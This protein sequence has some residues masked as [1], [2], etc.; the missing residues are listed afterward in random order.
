MAI[1]FTLWAYGRSVTATHKIPWR[2][3]AS[4]GLLL[5]IGVSVMVPSYRESVDRTGGGATHTLGSLTT[6][7][8]DPER[9]AAYIAEGQPTFLYFT[10]DWCVTCKFNERTALATDTV[11]DAFTSRGIK[12][13]VADWTAEDPVI[14]E[15]LEKYDRIGVPLY[16][17]FPRGSTVESATVLPQA[18]LPHIVVDAIVNAD[19]QS[20]KLAFVSGPAIAGVAPP[21]SPSAESLWSTVES[22][23]AAYE[24]GKRPEG[25]PA[26]SAAREL[27]EKHVDHESAQSAAEF[28]MRRTLGHREHLDSMTFSIRTMALRFP[29]YDGWPEFIHVLDWVIPPGREAEIDQLFQTIVDNSLEPVSLASARYYLASR[30]MRQANAIGLSAEARDGFREKASQVAAGLSQGVEDDKLQ[31][32]RRY[33]ADGTMVPF[34]TLEEAE[35][36]LLFTI[37][38]LVVG[39]EIPDVVGARLDGSDQR[40]SELKGKTLLIDFWATWCPPCIA[41]LPKLN[42]LKEELAS[43]GFEILSISVDDSISTISQFQ[44]SK[45]MPWTH[46]HA[47]P[48]GSILGDWVVRAYPTYMLLDADGKLVA[49][50]SL[51][52]EEFEQTIRNT[53]CRASS[54]SDC[55]TVN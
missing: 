41:A 31:K 19:E 14:T 23:L 38:N 8:F 3:T 40:L 48:D 36:D 28:L 43:S 39:D 46:W 12:V 52:D 9:M 24:E 50:Q 54:S 47:G 29:G 4:V 35:K 55:L 10:A 34:P 30:L 53:V 17:Y 26:I 5:C 51:F 7:N 42:T 15:W 44:A 49:R 45:P 25:S 18:L 33:F 2:V 22:Y 16:L 6:E 27:L 20:N 1:I 21:T 13:V 11:A 37:A 32:R